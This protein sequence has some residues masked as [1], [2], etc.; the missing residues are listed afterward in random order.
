MTEVVSTLLF[1]L[2][3]ASISVAGIL[4]CPVQTA[5]MATASNAANAMMEA[6]EARDGS[7]LHYSG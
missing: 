1:I 5:T 4:E 3:C 2:L 7:R 6:R